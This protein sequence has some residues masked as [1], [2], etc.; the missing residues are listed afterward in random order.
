MIVNKSMFPVDTGFS[1]I[2][3]LQGRFAT[4]QTQLGTGQKS[5]TLAGMGRDLPVSLSV[6]SRLNSI[7]AYNSSI[8]QVDLRL[9]FYDNA[10]TRFDKIEGEART[11]ATQGQYG[12]N[13]INMATIPGLSKA[14]LDEVVTMLN[15]DIAGRY[16]F[17][18]S[19]TD[20]APV[21]ST[22][23]LMDG[24]GGRAGYKTV[25]TERKMADAGADGRGRLTTALDTADPTAVKVTLA[26]DGDHPFGL[27]LSTVSSVGG[28]VALAANTAAS[29]ADIAFTFSAPPNQI[30]NGESV[31][32]GFTLPDGTETQ[33]TLKAVDA[34]SATGATNEFVIGADATATA[35]AFQTALNASLVK[36]GDQELAAASTY[37]ASQNFFNGAGEPALRVAGNNPYAATALRVASPTDTVAWYSGQSP[38]VSASNM[39]RLTSSV[40]GSGVTLKENS[41]ASADYGFRISAASATTATAGSV[42]AAASGNPAT[43]AI[44][45]ADNTTLAANDSISLTLTDPGGKTR[46]IKLTAVT[47]KAGAGQ[48][49]IGATA[50]E[51]AAN[52]EKAMTRSVTEAAASAEGN[53][54]Q[55]VSASIEDAGR[56]SYGMQANES[57][58]LRLVRSLAAMS[59]ETYPEIS[60][61][62]TDAGVA[63][64]KGRFDAMARRQQLELSESHNAE[65]GSIEMIT[66]EMGMSR[67]ALN[68]ASQRHTSYK[69]QLDG[70]LGDVETVSKEDV[71]MEIMA[72]Q[73][74]LTASYQATAMIS[75]L[76]LVNFLK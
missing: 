70:L 60:G 9:T 33:M 25:V 44:N 35:T 57:G 17:G 15:S 59:V 10:L 32:L 45:V 3:K 40:S 69:L 28:K 51:T 62:Q 6:R 19:S 71:A 13:N 1:V 61:T 66:N 74:R 47:G 37:A 21:P 75:Q 11:S 53:P 14:R 5:D 39:G 2:S 56:V 29:P 31:T 46:D 23:E 38:A 42:T 64:A 7:A 48:F 16:L 54:R 4:L 27:K 72:V 52:I 20:R 8:E 49:T 34:A 50:A 30:A 63:A 68:A 12:T 65:R 55:S 67:A 36:V 18:G 26:E 43:L 24:V 22:D 73:T 41:P 76:S 58:Y